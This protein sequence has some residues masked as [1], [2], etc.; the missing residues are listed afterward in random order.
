VKIGIN[1]LLWTSKV[2]E[3]HYPLFGALKKMGYDGVEIPVFE[4]DSR[5]YKALGAVL[6]DQ[7]LEATA[8][9]VMSAGTN[10]ISPDP[11]IRQAAR[12]RLRWV[13]DRS[14]EFGAEILCGP[15]HSALGVFSGL[16]PTREEQDRGVEFF[17]EMA[18]H[19]EAVRVPL[20]LE[21]LNRFESYFLT[22]AS[23]ALAFVD[24][25]DRPA[26]GM[27]WDTFH[28][29]IEEKSVAPLETLGRRLVHVHLSENDRGTPGTGQVH[30]PE[31]FAALRRMG[32]DRWLVIEAFGRALPD[33][34]AATRVWRDLF[35][36][37]LILC[38]SGLDFI[39]SACRT[40]RPT[41]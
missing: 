13:L 32:Y 37:P 3:S 22:T 39:R 41:R 17:R 33:L 31:T 25:I 2:G 10:P 8:I 35:D 26:C 29:H 36:D 9:T 4:G 34:A 23:D 21:Y 20:A 28:A 11:K 30:W 1:F 15:L 14:G 19:A 27:M 7:G 18:G 40:G 5:G 12:D 38:E 16:P 6:R 24:A